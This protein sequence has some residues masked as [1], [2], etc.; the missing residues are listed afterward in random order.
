MTAHDDDK[1]PISLASER[2]AR[3]RDFTSERELLTKELLAIGQSP[4]KAGA[5]VNDMLLLDWFVLQST[6]VLERWEIE[7]TAEACV[8]LVKIMV[9]NWEK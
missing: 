4:E 3:E 9:A 1:P 6:I 8:E 2:K 5:I 7:P